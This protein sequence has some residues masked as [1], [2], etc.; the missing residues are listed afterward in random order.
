MRRSGAIALVVALMAVGGLVAYRLS[1]PVKGAG[2]SQR[3]QPAAVEVASVEHGTIELR[4]TFTG[5]LDARA[6]FVVAANVG[7]RVE[8]LLVDLADPVSQGQV[9]AELDDAEQSAGVAEAAAELAVQRA[10]LAE[11]QSAFEIAERQLKR[12]E[13]LHREGLVADTELDAAKSRHLAESTRLEVAKAQVKQGAAARRRADVRSAY[14]KVIAS[15]SGDTETRFVAERHVAEG[16]TVAPH[17]PLV[18]VVDL[19]PLIAVI[20]VTERD[21][22]HLRIDQEATLTTEA[23]PDQRFVGVIQRIAPA[24]NRSSRQARVEIEV[25]N[26]DGRLKPGMFV[27]AELVLARAEGATIVPL[28]A[29][30]SRND[31][32][33][34]FVVSD[35]GS[36]VAWH[37][38]EEGIRQGERVQVTGAGIEGRVV[39]IGHQLI[40][41]GSAVIIPTQ[42]TERATEGP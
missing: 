29:L 20:Y 21:Y 25:T 31:E 10:N 14:T 30:A 28:A 1:G 13:T 18:T 5:T 26:E 37:P 22:G 23:F 8:R 40:D 34:V 27:R 17:D 2:S 38:V 12:T 33:G 9:V 41:H 39:T 42:P 15:W 3:G 6:R 24:F 4:R 11:A 35:D 32:T 19:A 7:G 36:R 16:D